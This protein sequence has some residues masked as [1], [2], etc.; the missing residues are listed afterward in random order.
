LLGAIGALLGLA[1]G[2]A[3]AFA[4]VRLPGRTLA[5]ACFAARRPTSGSRCRARGLLSRRRDRGRARRFLPALDAARTP[6][7]RA[8][9]AGDEQTLFQRATP[10]W[11]GLLLLGLGAGLSQLGPVNDLPLFGYAAIAVRTARVD[12]ARAANCPGDLRLLRLPANPPSALAVGQLQAAPGQAAVSLAA[13]VAS[14]S[15]MAAMAIMVASFRES[16]HQWLDAVLP[17]ELYFRTSQAGD[18]AQLEPGF[19]AQVR[20]PAA[21]GAAPS[22]C[23]AAVS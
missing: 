14:F 4:A 18:T 3:V 17:A 13:I 9:K 21:G 23:A 12:R 15:L 19:E 2:Y 1:L 7:A 8:L 22:S 5:P 20:A 10:L 11:P 6:P 16:V